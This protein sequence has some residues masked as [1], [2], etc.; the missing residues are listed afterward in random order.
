[1]RSAW[2]RVGGSVF[3]L[4]KPAHTLFPCTAA[5]VDQ[6]QPSVAFSVGVRAAGVQPSIL[7]PR[8]QQRIG[9]NRRG[10]VGFVL[11]VVLIARV[12]ARCRS[13]PAVAPSKSCS[14]T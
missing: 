13:F 3:G 14:D 5:A 10:K 6:A 12:S 2:E 9:S 11:A 8:L 4:P 7:L 1:M